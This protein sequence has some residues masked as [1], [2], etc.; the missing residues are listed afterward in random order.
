MIATQPP[1][2]SEGSCLALGR[3]EAGTLA[4]LA[5]GLRR[6]GAKIGASLLGQKRIHARIH[7]S[8]DLHHGGCGASR[9]VFAIPVALA[10]RAWGEALEMELPAKALQLRM[11]DWVRCQDQTRHVSHYFLTEAYWASL[12][13]P[14]RP[15]SI[16]R[17][18]D[19]LRAGKL[20]YRDTKVYSRYLEMMEQGYTIMRN[21]TLINSRAKLDDY[22]DRFVALYRSIEERGVMRMRD[23]RGDAGV[24]GSTAPGGKGRLGRNSDIGVAIGPDGTLAALPGAQHRLAVA[25]ALSLERV[26]VQIRMIHGQWLR[27]AVEAGADYAAA[28]PAALAQAIRSAGAPA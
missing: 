5:D 14:I 9:P 3:G 19:Y 2:S 4:V 24:P 22:F 28:L 10:V 13:R 20:A 16:M 17:E 7:Q 1:S 25:H 23:V 15:S 18:A 6:H 27:G 8:L 11:Y 12:V 21:R 26:P